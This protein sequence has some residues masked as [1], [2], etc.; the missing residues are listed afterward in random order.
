MLSKILDMVIFLGMLI[1]FVLLLKGSE[2]SSNTMI[3]WSMIVFTTT[4]ILIGFSIALSLV[5]SK[6]IDFFDE[7]ERK[8]A[9]FTDEEWKEGKALILYELSNS[10]SDKNEPMLGCLSGKRG[11]LSINQ[12][13]SAI[14]SEDEDGK[15][16][17]KMEI[18]HLRYK[19]QNPS[20]SNQV[21]T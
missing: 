11:R 18:N 5:L 21:V 13:I 12:L 6:I 19:N 1:G 15:L 7:D 17:I 3:V 20:L 2:K 4:S 16:H 8:N 10:A 9:P 14:E